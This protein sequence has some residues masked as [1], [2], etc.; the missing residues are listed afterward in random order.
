VLWALP[1]LLAARVA[2]THA[3]GEGSVLAR[4]L[5]SADDEAPP[6]PE[7]PLPS[8]V[9]VPTMLRARSPRR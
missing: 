7:E 4:F 2:A 9:Q 3:H 5:R 1:L 6:P 8:R